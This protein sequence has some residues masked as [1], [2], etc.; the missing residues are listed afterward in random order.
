MATFDVTAVFKVSGLA[1]LRNS[2]RDIGTAAAGVQRNLGRFGSDA[3]RFARNIGIAGAAAGA[4]LG[5]TAAR[6]SEFQTG[7]TE[8]VTLLNDGSFSAGGLQSGIAD[9]QEGILDLRRASG[10]T[11]ENLNQGLFDLISAGIEA[12]DA[13]ETLGVAT[14]LAI[15]GATETNVAVDAITST[16]GAYGD[17]AGSA[18]QISQKFFT[19]QVGGKTTVEELARS[20]GLVA[21]QASAAGINFDELLG[22]VS[23]ATVA[24]IRTNA[25]FTGLRGA[26]SNIQAPTAAAAKEASDLGIDFSSAALR[27]QGLVGVLRSVTES[28]NF[29]EDSFV[30]LF[31]AVEARNFALALANDGFE[32]ADSII[33]SVGNESERTA[34]FT[35]A[36]AEQ[37]NTLGFATQQLAGTFDALI[38]RIGEQ[39]SPALI[40]FFNLL[41]DLIVEFEPEIIAFFEDFGARALTF[42]QTLRANFPELVETIRSAVAGIIVGFRL[43]AAS[44]TEAFNVVAPILGEVFTFLDSIAQ[45]LGLNSGLTLALL[46]AFLQLTGGLRLITSGLLLATSL[47][48]LFGTIGLGVLN[49]VIRFGP[50]LLGLGRSVLGLGAVFASVGG[51]IRLFGLAI[52]GLPIIALIAGIVLIID[53]LFGLENIVQGVVDIFNEFGPVVL[54]IFKNI[55][56]G[57]SELVQGLLSLFG[58]FL[59]FVATIPARIIGFFDP[60]LGERLVAS[61]RAA[62]EGLGQS[63]INVFNRVVETIT[64]IF[65]GITRFF[66][67]TRDQVRQTRQE[68]EQAQEST[69]GSGFSNLPGIAGFATGGKVSGPGTGTSDSILAKLSNGEYVINAKSVGRFGTG[70]FDMLNKGVMPMFADGGLVSALQSSTSRINSGTS[71]SSLNPVSSSPA[72]VGRPLNLILPGGE[73][74]Q[75][76]T[77]ENTAQK[78]QRNLRKSDS[79]KSNSLPGWY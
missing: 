31:G 20:V 12:G 52:I 72:R 26:I 68:I 15:A 34:N 63:I 1:S 49:F 28:A 18:E 3:T 61:I 58:E 19:A 40:E 4:A 48:R 17:A 75:A 33:A 73:I 36:L 66:S 13:V 10:E 38:V 24:G 59:I 42:V 9:L 16:L 60:Q 25:A 39:L 51:L 2:F 29:T 22:T 70:L 43:F 78:L 53:E 62:F 7:F 5:G 11:F 55:F 21:S 76:T 47:L 32:R 27:S 67:D 74:V 41:R 44:V 6:F 30:R 65:S 50:L 14:N 37:Q 71:I 64:S 57:A 46:A 35:S 45:V 54:N 77:D 79:L 56:S 8:V 69:S 23:S